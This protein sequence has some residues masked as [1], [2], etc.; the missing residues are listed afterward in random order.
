MDKHTTVSFVISTMHRKF[1]DTLAKRMK[2]E[3][4]YVIV[5]QTDN[6]EIFYDNDKNV[7]WIN[8]TTRGLSKSRNIAIRNC[9][10]EVVVLSDDDL[11]YVSNAKEIIQNSFDRNQNYDVI[12]FMVDGIEQHFK[13]YPNKEKVISYIQS[14]KLS[15]VQIAIRKS[16]FDNASVH[17][18]ERFGSGSKYYLGEENI[19]LFDIL[20]K[21]HKV[22]FIPEKIADLHIGQ[23]TWFEGYNREY[24]INRGASYRR[25]SR[26]M[27]LPLIMQFAIRKRSLYKDN[28]SLSCAIR[29]MLQG[30]KEFSRNDSK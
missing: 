8:S 12:A 20:K 23:S 26:L 18:D 24:F 14:M 30:S 10:S 29:Y 15:S 28:L 27:Y 21:G 25:M 5:N 22:K 9:S 6:N 7:K 16:V 19:L 13:D 1:D 11:E 4:D 2:L 3:S 17:F